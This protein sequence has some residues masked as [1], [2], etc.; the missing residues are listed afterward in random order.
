MKNF[1]VSLLLLIISFSFF[2]FKSVKRVAAK[3]SEVNTFISAE[4]NPKFYF[5]KQCNY[6]HNEKG[7]IGPP[8]SFVKK[9]YLKK[10]PK[11]NDFIEK[12]TA[13]ILNP[14]AT[15]RLIKNNLGKYDVM[16]PG[17]FDD[18]E[19]IIQVVKYIYDNIRVPKIREGKDIVNKNKLKKE[20]QT[21][22]L[23]VE[24]HRGQK[25]NAL[26]N[27][28]RIHFKDNGFILDK[29][30]MNELNKLVRFLKNNKKIHIEIQNYTDSRGSSANNLEIT[31]K[32]AQTIKNYLIGKGIEPSR[33]IAKGY[34]E[35]NIINRCVNGIKCSKKEHLQNRRT[36]FVI[37]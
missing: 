27:L 7:K 17:M 1:V 4:I 2:S 6:C 29:Q 9:M 12:M 31:R 18:K 11:A 37:R 20:V 13:F 26:L 16:P 8:M 36:E 32:R 19:K 35:S 15:N 28:K 24:I 10:Y 34:G 21:A 14:T 22:I 23:T 33:L 5:E 25:L 30:D 3:E